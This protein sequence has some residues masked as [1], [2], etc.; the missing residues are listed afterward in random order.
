VSLPTGREYRI[1]C[2]ANLA[3]DQDAVEEYSGTGSI[4]V[5]QGSAYLS[6]MAVDTNF[7]RCEGAVSDMCPGGQAAEDLNSVAK[8]G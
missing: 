6:N 7:R 2:V 8:H 4:P 1:V 3:L 5:P